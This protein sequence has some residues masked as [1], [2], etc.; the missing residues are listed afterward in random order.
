MTTETEST[1]PPVRGG[2]VSSGWLAA[3]SRFTHTD[4]RKVGR[5]FA[6]SMLLHG[7]GL[8]LVVLVM[9]LVPEKVFEPP[10]IEKYDLIFVQTAGPAGGGGGGN[11]MPDPPKKVE[12][13]AEVPK[14]PV[15]DPVPVPVEVPP[16]SL[17]APIQ[18]ATPVFQSAG[19]L[20]GLSAAPALGTGSGTGSGPGKGPGIGPGSGGGMGDG[21]MGPGSGASP[22]TL[23][24]GLDPKY[25][26]GAMRAKLQGIVILEAVVTESGGVEGVKVVK[27]LDAVHGL[28]EEAVRTARQWRFRPAM[29]KGQ[30]VK[31]LVEIQMT[32]NLR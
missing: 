12:M 19:A 5:A 24:R 21:P 8:A 15:V 4:D 3:D 25:T 6:A 18:T 28:D 20:T 23:L 17:V 7:A 2:I 31:Y 16:P 22:P 13:R 11:Q 1:T 30:A 27:S 29:F 9:S 26:T 32:F 14:P 10:V